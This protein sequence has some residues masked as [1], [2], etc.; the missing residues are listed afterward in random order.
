[1]FHHVGVLMHMR[2][3]LALH[4]G[5]YLGFGMGSGRGL[6]LHRGQGLR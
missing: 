4:K 2:S 3:G 6:V 5:C 1:M